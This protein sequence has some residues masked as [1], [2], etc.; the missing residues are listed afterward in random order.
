METGGG[1][2]MEK[3]SVTEEGGKHKSMTGSN[4][5]VTPQRRATGFFAVLFL[6][7]H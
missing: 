6:A 4:A 2:G 1:D 3:G 7:L 5:T